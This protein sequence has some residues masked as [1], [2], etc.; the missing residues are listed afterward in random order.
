MGWGG[1]GLD[2][3][4]W[5][6]KG[7]EWGWGG[8][9][10][11]LNGAGMRWGEE[12]LGVDPAE[13]PPILSYPP[14]IRDEIRRAYILKRPCQPRDHEF[15]Q[16]DF[17]GTPRRFVSKWF[18]EYSNLLEYSISVDAAYCLPCYLFQGESIHQGGGNTFSTKEFRNWYRKDSFATH[19]GPLNSIHDQSKRKCEDFM[20]EE[21]SIEA[22]FYKLDEESKNEYRVRREFVIEAFIGLVHIKDTSA[23]SLKKVIVDVLAHHSI[24]LAYVR[25][26]CYDGASNMQCELGGLKTL[27]RQESR[28]AHSVQCFAHQL[29]L[30]LVAV[31]KRCVQV[32]ELVLLT[33]NILNVLGAFCKRADEFR[34]SQKEKLQ[35]ALDMAGDTRWGSHYKSFGNFIHNFVSIVDVLD[36]LVENASTSEEK[37]SASGFLRSC[38]TFEAIFLLHLMTD[39]LGITNDLNVSLQKKKQDI[40]NA[41]ILVKIANTR[42]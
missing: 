32:G 27:I 28:S 26:Q 18:D 4:G 15:P 25:G 1:K 2:G 14:N 9:G 16:T 31:S 3:L 36:S 7:A 29:Q 37:A 10:R 12:G 19:I 42:L 39:V 13:R 23:L 6:G 21:Q 11:G 38:Q 30:T 40:A 41:M 22:A 5:A 24:T 20:R 17:S 33:S 35:E 8:V 34:E